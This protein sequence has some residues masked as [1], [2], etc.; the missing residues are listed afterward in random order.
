MQISA[1]Q[2]FAQRFHS[3]RVWSTNAA[4]LSV[5]IFSIRS[6][7]FLVPFLVL[8][9]SLVFALPSGR[10]LS[11]SYGLN[12]FIWAVFFCC[13][14]R[15]FS[16][17]LL[18]RYCLMSGRSIDGFNGFPFVSTGERFVL[19]YSAFDKNL[20]DLL[21]F[22]FSVFAGALFPLSLDCFL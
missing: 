1:E 12:C 10:S 2:P 14:I 16:S 3:L 21:S 18:L 11:F 19:S 5:L 13:F 15:D 20:F 9:I 8:L 6:I 17:D 22:F 7:I 4:Q